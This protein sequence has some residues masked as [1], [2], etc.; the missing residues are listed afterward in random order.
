MAVIEKDQL[1]HYV[2]CSEQKDANDGAPFSL[3]SKA[4]AVGFEPT[5]LRLTAAPEAV[6]VDDF[7]LGGDR[8]Q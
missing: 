3:H 7:N 5:T 1:G 4:P 2:I 8:H 6:Q